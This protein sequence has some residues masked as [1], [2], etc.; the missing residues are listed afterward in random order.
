M[1][2]FL[3]SAVL[4]AV[5]ALLAPAMASADAY[6]DRI[7]S[8]VARTNVW[9]NTAAYAPPVYDEWSTAC[10][11]QKVAMRDWVYSQTI[12]SR[13]MAVPLPCYFAASPGSDQ[14]AVLRWHGAKPAGTYDYYE[15]WGANWGWDSTDNAYEWRARWGGAANTTELPTVNG[16]RVWPGGMGT[17]ASGIAFIP[18]LILVSELQA[19]VIPHVVGL[20]VPEA[21]GTIHP[22][23]TRTDGGG[24]MATN[25]YC[26]EY[27]TLLKFPAGYPCTWTGSTSFARVVCRAMRDYGAMVTDQTRDTVAMRGENYHRPY[28]PWGSTDPYQ[29][30]FQPCSGWGCSPDKFNQFY[31]FPWGAL[32]RAN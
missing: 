18:G 29:A 22:P 24:T 5:L 2:W 25:P 4:V 8:E 11:L 26:M 13:W 15:F 12:Q 6:G 3:P 19:G 30:F 31:G 21:C 23:A 32:T 1:R 27:G 28:A 10:G 14:E 20:E 7:A 17:Q 9:L 16:V